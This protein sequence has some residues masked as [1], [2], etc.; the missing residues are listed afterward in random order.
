MAG[1]YRIH[2]ADVILREDSS[3]DDLIDIIE[4]SR[5]YI[6]CMYVMNKIDQISVEELDLI[7]RM[8]NYCPVRTRQSTAMRSQAKSDMRERERVAWMGAL[9]LH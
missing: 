5:I 9:G 7:D 6:P 3:V 8:P 2:N 4:G 1:E